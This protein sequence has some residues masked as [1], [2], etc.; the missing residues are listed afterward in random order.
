MNVRELQPRVAV[1]K[2]P[3]INCDIETSHAFSLAGAKPETVLLEDLKSGEKTLSDYQ[4]IA[5]SGGFSYGDDLGSGT[6][7]SLELDSYLGNQV[8]RF[9]E[10]G[11]MIGICNGFQVLVRS[12]LLPMGTLSERSATLDR[13][14]SGKFLSRRVRLSVTD[15]KCVFLN[16]EDGKSVEFQVAHG[17]GKMVMA[18]DVLKQMEENSQVVFRYVDS[19]NRL[20]QEYPFN[21]NGS[22]H[23]I[24]GVCDPTGRILGLMPH[25]ERSI[26]K[27]QY[28]N[29][30]R[31]S[32]DF[33]PEGLK[34]FERMVEYAREGI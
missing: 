13:N 25:P 7:M 30:R 20:T 3:G 26:I 18:Q 6:V 8:Q 23:A 2:A 15:S 29:W 33:Q 12:G 21:P 11:L 27:S 9:K 17:E 10:K 4:I 24:A 19:K 31:L 14:D 34:V 1:L 5:L 32:V 28:P 22:P 16:G